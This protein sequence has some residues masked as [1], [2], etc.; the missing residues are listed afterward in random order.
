[1]S[2][3]KLPAEYESFVSSADYLLNE[4]KIKLSI[5]KLIFSIFPDKCD[6]LIDLISLRDTISNRIEKINE[7]YI[8]NLGYPHLEIIIPT[9]IKGVPHIQ[10]ELCFGDNVEDEWYIVST[11]L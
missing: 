10:G 6:Q 7:H 4:F 8:W 2:T 11:L 5:D 3:F 9:E 1:M